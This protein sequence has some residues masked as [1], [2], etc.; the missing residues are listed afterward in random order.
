[1]TANEKKYLKLCIFFAFAGAVAY[2]VLFT[3]HGHRLVTPEGRRELIAWIDRVVRS[4]GPLGPPLFVL[5]YLLG[6]Q[7]LPA[8]PFNA[9]GAFLFGKFLGSILNI[10]AATAG[11]SL[12]FFLG[13]YLLRDFSRE[14]LTGKLGELDR[15]AG[16]HGF[17]IVFYLRI[18]W[19]PF[20]VLNYGAGATRIRFRDYF[21]GSFLGLT[22]SIVIA[23]L[24]FGGIREVI[25]SYRRPSDLLTFDILFPAALLCA[26]FFLPAILRRIRGEEAAEPAR[27]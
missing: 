14:L 17:S 4:A 2:G 3:P 26:S 11:A 15:K 8:T 5:L 27:E 22:P 23:T 25:A 6:V 18:F 19:F 12:S 7:A 21:W 10:A 20:I 9:A 16:R 1:M 13:R 24:F